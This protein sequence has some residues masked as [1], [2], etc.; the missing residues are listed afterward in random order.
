[1]MLQS[2][3]FLILSSWEDLR[4]KCIPVQGISVLN[5]TTLVTLKPWSACQQENKNSCP[6][7]LL[8][9]FSLG[10]TEL[11]LLSCSWG[12][13][14]WGNT[15][16][17]LFLPAAISNTSFF[18]N[19]NSSSQVS[20]MTETYWL[21]IKAYGNSPTNRTY[22][23]ILI[24]SWEEKEKMG[25]DRIIYSDKMCYI[26]I[27]ILFYFFFVCLFVCFFVFK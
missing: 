27:K 25:E 19:I 18:S 23:T 8:S 14:G 21:K 6:S 24:L 16:L 10:K 13:V 5:H 12:L 26:F 22:Y 1:M 4:E 9:K 7:P 20:V 15:L 2:L 17:V 3:A 11:R